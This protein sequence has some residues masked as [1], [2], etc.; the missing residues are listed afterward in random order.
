MSAVDHDVDE[1]GILDPPAPAEPAPAPQVEPAE[2]YSNHGA[3]SV[4]GNG[5]T[6][7]GRDYH[8]QSTVNIYGRDA[9]E[10]VLAL[11]RPPR[12]SG[13]GLQDAEALRKLAERYVAPNGL[14]G[15]EPGTAFRTVLDRRVVM[16]TAP[17]HESGQF[18]A[19]RRLGYELQQRQPDLVVR[20]DM[21]D[22][23]SGLQAE[24]LLVDHEPAAVLIDLRNAG[25]EEFDQVRLGLVKFTE[26]LEDHQSYLILIIPHE[27]ARSFE[28]NFPERVHQLGRP[29]ASAVFARYATVPNAED[30]F[31]KV[32]PEKLQHL[33]PPRIK[34]VAD[35]V[36]ERSARGEDPEQALDAALHDRLDG[37]TAHLRTKIQQHQQK[38][39]T[40]WMSLMLAAGLLEEASARHIVAASNR[41]LVHSK[42][43]RHEVVPLLQPSPYTKLEKL[44]KDTFDLRTRAFRPRGS[45][46]RVLQH[47]WREHDALRKTM[48]EW[49]GD[50]PSQIRDLSQEELERVADRA[51]ELA[52]QGGPSIAISL[53]DSW[54]EA[55]GERFDAYRRSIAVRLLT[56]TATDLSLG[57]PIRQKLWE[58]SR[59]SN[60]DR[61]L[62][63]AEVCAGIGQAFPRIALT[64][65]KHLANAESAL[66]R[67][68][69]QSAVE[70][71]GAELGAS[72]FLRHLADWFT[73]ASPARLLLMAE[74]VARV[75]D[76]RTLEVDEEAAATF[77]QQ[78][79]EAMPPDNL[80]PVVESWLRTAAQAEPDRRA[81]LVEPLV[82]ATK[83]DS[84]RIAQLLYASRFGSNCLDL[85]SL[86]ESLSDVV[87]QLWTRLDEVDPARL[88]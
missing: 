22:K 64:R 71:I 40:E 10:A 59:E 63:T 41:L 37:P 77:W 65:L 58:W 34:E 47:V 4:S 14:L 36:S 60:A 80:R 6:T 29:P 57:K 52:T 86:D 27:H 87:N 26:R 24:S 25:P 17:E 16:L 9:A 19:G 48:L 11:A 72:T 46:V 74:S 28:E 23:D 66:V 3:I 32:P 21:I 56:T 49:I 31:N 61:Q 53:A 38:G 7:T 33:W 5:N 76:G 70:Q 50:L 13:R 1:F 20:E 45:G 39:D 8:Q 78:A 2:N 55:K 15:D 43:E 54:A 83:H 12:Q 82:T 68:A 75:L 35:D 62:L 69:V 51:A 84:R 44:E 81:G 73:D 85:S 18:S 42:V 67:D 79:L 88:Q 30:L